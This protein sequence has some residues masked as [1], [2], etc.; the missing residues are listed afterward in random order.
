[1]A[2]VLVSPLPG[3]ERRRRV[4]DEICGIR[5]TDIAV[6]AWPSDHGRRAGK[7]LEELGLLVWDAGLAAWRQ[8]PRGQTKL[9]E[10][11]TTHGLRQ[12]YTEDGLMWVVE[13][14]SLHCGDMLETLLADGTWLGL[15][16]ELAY[17][18]GA[19]RPVFYLTT[20]AGPPF[21]CE[22]EGALESAIFR[23]AD[24]EPELSQC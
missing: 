14:R 13:G 3:H 5:T 23:V 22:L 1:M 12:Q 6:L 15:R 10:I 24:D 11:L 8:T 4:T 19:R 18:R 17:R 16:F 7:R 9:Y 20:A 2:I 21:L